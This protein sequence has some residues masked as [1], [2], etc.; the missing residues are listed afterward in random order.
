MA[1]KFAFNLKKNDLMKNQI[2]LIGIGVALL[3][4]WFAYNRIY[5]KTMSQMRQISGTISNENQKL[6]VAK[7]LE[8]LQAGLNKYKGIFPKEADTSWLTE[9][10]SSMAAASGLEVKALNPGPVVQVTDFK[11]AKINISVSGRFNELGDFVSK[12]ENSKEFMKINSLSF[13]KNGERL[14]ADIAVATYFWKTGS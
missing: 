13:K 5:K 2:L 9:K 4:I 8:D 11:Y 7:R 6:E 10:V 14:D 3:C 1:F 12:V